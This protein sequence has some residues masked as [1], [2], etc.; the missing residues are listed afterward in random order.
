VCVFLLAC[1]QPHARKGKKKKT[2]E[3]D[4]FRNMKVKISYILEDGHVGRKT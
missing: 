1:L 2:S 3:A 4:S